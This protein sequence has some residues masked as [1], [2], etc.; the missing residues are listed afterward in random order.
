MVPRTFVRPGPRGPGRFVLGW[1][2]VFFIKETLTAEDRA[3]WRRMAVCRERYARRGDWFVAIV[4]LPIKLLKLLGLLL[5]VCGG[6][7]LYSCGASFRNGRY[8]EGLLYTVSGLINSMSGVCLFL[9]FR[10][11]SMRPRR[12]SKKDFPPS[13]MPDMPVRA[14]F[15]GDGSFTFW[16][17][18]KKTRLGYQAVAAAWE[19]EGRFYLFFQDRPPLVLP[20]R[21]LGRW[22]PEDFRD[23]LER[24]LGKPIERAGRRKKDQD[25]SLSI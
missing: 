4:L 14:V 7:I 20:K 12:L 24:E 22:M 2:M 1:K 16:E 10:A 17:S 9:L 5:F 19:D 23:F 8:L 6:L 15:F 13:D 21:G 25:L 18:S 11:P 3:A